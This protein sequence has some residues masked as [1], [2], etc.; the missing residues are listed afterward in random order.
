MQLSLFQPLDNE[1]VLLDLFQAYFDAR[2]NKR[3]TINALKF[4]KNFESELFRL[5]DEIISWTYKPQPS[6]CFIINKPVKREIFA[7]T[8]RDR[9]I[10]HFI[11]NH[12]YETFDKSFINDSYSC[13][14]G[15]GTHYGIKRID[16]FIRSCSENYH[17]DCYILKLDISGYFMAIN[18]ELLYKKVMSLLERKTSKLSVS[19]PLLDDL[20][21]QT[22][23]NDPTKNC[24]MRG[25]QKDWNGLPNS[26][27]LFYSRKGCGLPIGNLTS[28]LFSNVYLNEFDHFVKR[29]LHIKHYGRYVD[30]FVIIHSDK[31]YL[32]SIIPIIKNYLNDELGLILHPGKVYL[33]HYTKGVQYL[34]AFIKPYRI[35][36]AKRTRAQFYD[37]IIN[38]N[39]IV[40]DRKPTMDE[41]DAFVSSINSYLGLM[42]HYSSYNFRKKLLYKN[43]SGY[44]WNYVYLSGGIARLVKLEKTYTGGIRGF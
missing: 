17:K 19:L 30:D 1:K 6:I 37:S 21:R 34:G 9:V 35:Y 23:F 5:H 28:Q 3:N 16:K 25:N 24:I 31:T 44:W 2:R 27:S 4:E 29:D 41:Q 22:V 38:Q 36:P 11:Y 12:I 42:K 43:V 39:N 14:E 8:F 13:R 7:A 40:A 10:H 18:R 32:K 26:K 33:Q 20:I 15:K